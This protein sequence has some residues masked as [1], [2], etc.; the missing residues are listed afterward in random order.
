VRAL[1]SVSDKTNIDILAKFLINNKY[2]IIS[3][4]GTLKF[5]KDKGIDCI[6][7]SSITH[8]P[9]MLDGRVKTLH[10]FIHGGILHK[11]DNQEHLA[12]IK[13]HGIRPID[14]VCVNLYPF[15][16][17]TKKTDDF[18]EIIE[19]IDIGGP[20][21]IRASAKNFKDCLILTDISQYEPV[22]DAIKNKKD[23]F[24]F[25][26][27]LMIKA[28]ENTASY[29]SFIANYMGERYSDKFPENKSI[30]ATKVMDT[31][32]GENPHQQ[33]ALYQFD[34]YFDDMKVLKG[35]LSFNNIADI[36]GAVKII[37]NFA[38]KKCV[39][40]VKHGNACGFAVSDDINDAYDKSLICDTLSAYGGVI[41]IGDIINQDLAR[42]L[43]KIFFE[44]IISY[45]MDDKALEVFASKKRVKIIT[46][47]KN[48]TQ[49]KIHFKS[50]NGGFL[51]QNS[52]DITDEEVY[53]AKQV[54]TKSA[55]TAMMNDLNIANKIS[56]LT[57]SNCISC[58]K[59]GVLLAI[60]MGMTSR[61]DAMK[62][63]LDKA[64]AKKIDTKGSSISSEAF[65]PFKDSVELANRY[66][67]SAII[68][69]GGSIRDDE[70]IQC[71]NEND[72]ALYFS[73][74]RHFLH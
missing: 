27:D 8:F 68:E 6:D 51:L 10:P 56:A 63:A 3:T 42:K 40:I 7:I 30:T 52:D 69:P 50:I 70:V 62:F 49:N 37:S 74:K 19:N 13:K 35:E 32:Y 55:N 12:T 72:I 45:G 57:K 28:Y 41:A 39:A 14:L 47:S 65:F 64:V 21:L 22:M 38:D 58:V 15:V 25:R 54:S 71:A 24:E 59:D 46:I 61:I 1:I 60:G 29:D 4:G 53:N 16:E 34:D 36:D 2:E 33:G 67:I 23:N 31:R 66:N 17:T 20:S 73:G 48:N 5:L 18:D 9:E 43:N 44:V 11:R 26:R